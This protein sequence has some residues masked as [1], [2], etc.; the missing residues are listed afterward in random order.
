MPWPCCVLGPRDGQAVPALPA[1]PAA[2]PFLAIPA[3]SSLP[4][5]SRPVAMAMP[6]LPAQAQVVIQSPGI[7]QEEDAVPVSPLCPNPPHSQGEQEAGSLWD[8]FGTGPPC[9]QPVETSLV[10]VHPRDEGNRHRQAES[11][12]SIQRSRYCGFKWHGHPGTPGGLGAGKHP[13]HCRCPC[14]NVST[15]TKPNTPKVGEAPRRGERSH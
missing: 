11:P 4:M 9:L 2:C 8:H 12:T 13:V 3:P 6:S 14:G 7:L 10:L 5:T 1:L 15:D